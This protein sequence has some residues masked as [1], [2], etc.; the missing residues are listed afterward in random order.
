MTWTRKSRADLLLLPMLLVAGTI[1]WLVH[2]KA[3]DL[4]GRSPILNYDAAQYALAA[5][6]LAWHGRLATP[7][8]L[9]IELVTHASPPWPLAVVQPG[10][11]LFEAVVFKLVP[12]R[13]AVAGSDPRGL[14]TLL[15]PF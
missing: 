9:P 15:L 11:V 5:R 10:V 8:A 1:L 12:A 6:E 3:W 14:L 4:G 2:A 13:G 7:F